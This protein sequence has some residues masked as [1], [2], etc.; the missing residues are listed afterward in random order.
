M[1]AFTVLATPRSFAKQDPEPLKL[2]ERHG[3]RVIRLPK[4]GGELRPQ[5]MEYLPEADGIIAGLEPY[6]AE[7]LSRGVKLRVISRYGVGVD[8][9]DLGLAGARGIAVTNT[10]GANSDSVADLAMALMLCS[11]RQVCLM[12]KRLCAGQNEKPVSGV[13]MWKKTLGVVGTGRIGR[14][15]IERAGGFRMKVLAY[16][17]CPDQ[18]FISRH[19]GKY[20][21]LDTL[22]SQ[23]DFI[24]LHTPLNAETENMVDARRIGMMKKRAV[25]VNTARGGL[26]DEGA[27][28]SALKQGVI[29]AAA[30][31]ACQVE[32]ACGSKLAELDNC[33][34]TPHAGAA[35][36]EAGHNM[37]MMAAQ[38][39]LDILEKGSSPYIV[40]A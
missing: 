22:F 11:A 30:L 26:I 3:C 15:V 29:G 39:L 18:D 35:T 5:L 12:N 25:L 32:P 31:D 4:D 8:N 37:G 34:L 38:N 20:V 40:R 6:D 13:E 21:D 24:T 33:I 27:L 9:I 7:L 28:Y 1:F 14:G 23:S 10:P 17:A 2:L 36:I 19:Q 16:D